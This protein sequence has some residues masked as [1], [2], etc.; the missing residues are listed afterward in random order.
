M[1]SYIPRRL[2]DLGEEE[3]S[4]LVVEGRPPSCSKDGLLQFRFKEPG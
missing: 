4:G 2:H 1:S 3:L